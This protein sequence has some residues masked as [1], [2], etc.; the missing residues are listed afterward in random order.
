MPV[1]LA[2]LKP[3]YVSSAGSLAIVYNTMPSLVVVFIACKR[4]V[5]LAHKKFDMGFDANHLPTIVVIVAQR[6][7]ADQ[8]FNGCHDRNIPY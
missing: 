5:L 6:L 2:G 3:A 4:R 7:H 1:I 8:R